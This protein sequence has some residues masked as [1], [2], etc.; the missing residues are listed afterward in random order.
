MGKTNAQ[1]PMEWRSR[2]SGR[3]AKLEARIKELEAL[4][5]RP[6]S[7]KHNAGALGRSTCGSDQLDPQALRARA[8]R[9]LG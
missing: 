5:A 3:V 9:L 6:P 7:R 4:V 2:E 8:R 1:W